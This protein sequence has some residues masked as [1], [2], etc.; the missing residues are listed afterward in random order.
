MIVALSA[1]SPWVSVALFREDGE[2]LE[3][4]EREASRAQSSDLM[5]LLEELRLRDVERTGWIVDVGPG[6]FTGARIGVVIAKTLAHLDGV[7]LAPISSFDLMDPTGAASIPG[8]RGEWLVREI[9]QEPEVR[10]EPAGVRYGR[11]TAEPV[12]PLARHAEAVWSQLEFRDPLEVLPQYVLDP[13]IS[14]PK[15]PFAPGGA[16]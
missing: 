11:D 6:T 8:R 7:K 1:S 14:R 9:G 13:G 15:K 3:S 10:S 2:L 16:I 4:A 5:L 12:Y